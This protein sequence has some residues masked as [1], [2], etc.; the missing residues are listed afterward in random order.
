MGYSSLCKKAAVHQ[1][2]QEKENTFLWTEFKTLLNVGKS[3]LKLEEIMWN[4]DYAQV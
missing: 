1:W 2:F 3:V 4:S